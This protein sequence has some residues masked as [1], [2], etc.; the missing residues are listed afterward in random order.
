ME[1]PKTATMV[2][3]PKGKA[4]LGGAQRAGGRAGRQE[5]VADGQRQRAVAVEVEVVPEVEQDA[6][7]S[8]ELN[9]RDA[10]CGRV[11]V[12][13]GGVAWKCM[14]SEK[15]EKSV[16]TGNLGVRRAERKPC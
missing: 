8:V 9:A 7:E 5:H 6:L 16:T 4:Q 3:S 14:P 1:E 10:S 12:G 15:D 13:W 11:P 2:A